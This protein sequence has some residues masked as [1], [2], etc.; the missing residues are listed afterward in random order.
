M[1]E[2]RSID[3]YIRGDVNNMLPEMHQHLSDFR[4]RY[5]DIP[6]TSGYRARNRL[7]NSQHAYGR[8]FDFSVRGLSDD[9]K[10]EVVNWW[11]ERGATGIGYY[12]HSDSI[13][14][15]FRPQEGGF[16][17]W[18]PNYSRS[19]L[20]Q[21]P[22]WF[23]QIAAEHRGGQMPRRNANADD[24]LFT[25]Y[26]R[27]ETPA[28]APVGTPA[29]AIGRDG[30]PLAEITVRG[31]SAPAAR[32]ELLDRYMAP[33]PAA[34][35]GAAPAAETQSGSAAVQPGRVERFATGIARGAKDMLD[36]G[37]GYLSRAGASGAE[38]LA[39]GGILS[40][41]TAAAV[42]ASSDQTIAANQQEQAQFSAENPLLS[43][44]GLGRVG[45]NIAA[46]WMPAGLAARAGSAAVGATPLLGAIPGAGL[47]G[48]GA[49]AGATA[50]ALLGQPVGEGALAGAVAGPVAG[51]ASN[52]V[53]RGVNALT[54]GGV[55]R[56]TALLAQAAREQYGIPVTAGQISN[57]P[58]TRML[59]SVTSRIPGSGSGASREAQQVG[60]NR[61]VANTFGENAE[62]ITPDVMAAA[63]RR[64]GQEFDAVAAATPIRLDRQFIDGLRT[65]LDDARQ[66]LGQS[67]TQPL[68]HQMR[69]IAEKV[70][71]GV[72]SGESYQA[73]TRQGAPLSRAQQSGD[74]NVR[75]YANQIR[76]V[77]DDALQ[78]S[79]TPEMRETLQNA[80]RQY[81][82]MKTVEDLV[83]KSPNGD[84]SPALL[85]G[86]V[87]ANT[88]NMAYG[89]G[90]EQADL[91]RIGQRFLRDPPNS[92]TADR[93]YMMQLFGMG[94]LTGAGGVAAAYDPVM[95]AK[96]AGVA[97][98]SMLGARGVQSA[99]NS[100]FAA[101]RLINSGLRQP[102]SM[103]NMLLGPVPPSLAA[104]AYPQANALSAP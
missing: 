46:T 55:D 42:R 40:P 64:L 7:T 101:N 93:L 51:A 62:R 12:P 22:I 73:L 37:A 58:A 16:Q 77:L 1:A 2:N 60:F 87:R 4:S 71:G 34:T 11:R 6:M 90:G 19:S 76:E 81:R 53:Q 52:I 9:K 88:S 33:E 80:R 39:R 86:R 49:A 24:E 26:M 99:L 95:A 3:A 91:A 98:L 29:P 20:G 21:T 18:G 104:I 45:G 79:A 68:L 31:Q 63:K 17:A 13:H 47:A 38:L 44:G 83:E 48:G 100:N 15:D 43:A 75:F 65:T 56:N 70:Q 59:D 74:P 78:R 14:V 57:S 92:G 66:V 67:E 102:G 96:A 54:G 41:E 32:D 97:G 69:N 27:P 72:I 50:N 61:A 30:Q 94:G 5:A 35:S 23:Q 84:I 89:G 28:P 25:R 36:T 82:A 8:A 10:R 103:P 85:M